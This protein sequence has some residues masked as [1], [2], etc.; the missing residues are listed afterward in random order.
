MARLLGKGGLI[1]STVGLDSSPKKKAPAAPPPE[2][3]TLPVTVRFWVDREVS[4]A[5]Q[6]KTLARLPGVTAVAI[7]DSAKTA[8]LTYTGDAKGLSEFG[9]AL[10]GQGAVVDPVRFAGR[11]STT[12]ANLQRLPD[13]LKQLRGMKAAVVSVDAV[14]FWVNAAELD[15]DGLAALGRFTF[16]TCDILEGT[17]AGEGKSEDFKAMLLQTRGVLNADVSGTTLR[18]LS[19]KGKVA[20]ETVKKLAAP[21]ELDVTPVKK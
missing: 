8:T 10:N 15:L 14:E 20:M 19:L 5:N 3:A 4:I 9:N 17:L 6:Q 7:D 1:N 18:I 16:G 21:F 13:A 11:V 2:V 12:S